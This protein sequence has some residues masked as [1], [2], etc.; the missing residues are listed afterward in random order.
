MCRASFYSEMLFSEAHV[1]EEGFL[2]CLEDLI[3]SCISAYINR[4]KLTI[5]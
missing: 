2:E 1:V 3:P 4:Y 5:R